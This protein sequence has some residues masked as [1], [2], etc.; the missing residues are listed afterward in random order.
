MMQF[1]V[2]SDSIHDVQA[3]AAADLTGLMYNLQVLVKNDHR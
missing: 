2:S 3:V 1:S